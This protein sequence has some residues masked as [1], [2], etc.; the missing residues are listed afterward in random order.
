M[1]P[2]VMV[3]KGGVSEGVFAALKAELKHRE[4]LKVRFVA[5]KEECRDL[6]QVLAEQSG[7]QL[8]RVI[9][10]VAILFKAAE[11]AEDRQIVLP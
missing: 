11:K 5:R 8:V 1:E 6:A 3:G 7:A 9:G 10:Y 2:V 4:L